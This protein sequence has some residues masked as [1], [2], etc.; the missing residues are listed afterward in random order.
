MATWYPAMNRWHDQTGV[1]HVMSDD[2]LPICGARPYSLGGG[3]SAP[4]DSG[5]HPCKRC[6]K[7]A[8][9]KES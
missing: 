5:A 9:K 1:A 3:F 8:E 4:L 6:E 2:G 7:I